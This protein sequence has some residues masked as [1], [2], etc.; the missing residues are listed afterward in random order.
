MTKYVRVIILLSL[1]ISLKAQVNLI[2]NPSFEGYTL[3]PI[4]VDQTDRLVGWEKY[5]ESPDLFSSCNN[6]TFVGVPVNTYAFQDSIGPCNHNYIGLAIGTNSLPVKEFIGCKLV[7][8]LQKNTKYFFSMK[9]NLADAS[10][11]GCDKL[12]I[13]LYYN[14]P[15]IDVPGYTSGHFLINSSTI[16]FTTIETDKTLWKAKFG[17][18][19]AD[20]NYK[21]LLVGNFFD[22]ASTNYSQ[23]ANFPNSNYAYYFMDDFCLSTDSIF[24]ANYFYNCNT[25]NSLIEN[26]RFDSFS[27]FPI[28]S[29][30]QLTIISPNFIPASIEIIDFNGSCLRKMETQDFVYKID[31]DELPDGLYFVK[32]LDPQNKPYLRKITI[33]H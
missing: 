11:F 17:S 4:S 18:F 24:T 3:C 19:I 26:R 27:I 8:S 14:K 13:N 6:S 7:D 32:I 5:G 25:L 20:S 2:P 1:A 33:I 28:P 16:T 21:Y 12:G 9:I 15:F 10:N 31:I 29:N 30:K 23:V 22:I